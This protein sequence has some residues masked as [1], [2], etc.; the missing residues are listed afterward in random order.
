MP[1]LHQRLPQRYLD[2]WLLL[3]K[4]W[5]YSCAY[6]VTEETCKQIHSLAIKFVKGAQELYLQNPDANTMDRSSIMDSNIHALLH[7]AEGVRDMG[8]GWVTWAF[9][10]ERYCGTLQKMARSK[11]KLNESLA[12]AI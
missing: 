12:N 3:A 9:P 1:I 8:P 5:V 4:M 6:Q 10:I 11:L 7:L 2:H